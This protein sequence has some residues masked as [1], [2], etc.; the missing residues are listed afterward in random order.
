[1]F[2]NGTSQ[3]L[4]WVLVSF[5]IFGQIT[6]VVELVQSFIA[7]KPWAYGTA[8]GEAWSTGTKPIRNVWN[9]TGAPIIAGAQKEIATSDQ[10]GF[11]RELVRQYR[12]INDRF[13]PK[14]NPDKVPNGRPTREE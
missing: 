13:Y 6:K 10:S 12:K 4:L 14:N 7:G 8:M 11:V 1:L 2:T 9:Q 3:Q 5:V